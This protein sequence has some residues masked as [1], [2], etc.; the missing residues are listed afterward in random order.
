M[1]I[2][3]DIGGTK[4]RA[5]M[6][7]KRGITDSIEELTIKRGRPDALPRQ[8]MKMINMLVKENRIE[9]DEIGTVGIS[10]PGPFGFSN[11]KRVLTTPNICGGLNANSG[12]DNDWME[13]PLEE[14]LSRHFDIIMENDALSSALV[15]KRLIN[16]IPDD[17][18]YITWST[19]IGGGIVTGG[20][21]VKGSRG[22]A[23]HIGHMI[24]MKDGPLC[25]CGNHGD[26][27]SIASGSAIE[28]Q[29]GLEASSVF[30]SYDSSVE[31]RRIV[32]NAA[33]GFAAGLVSLSALFDTELFIIGG[34][35]FT[36]NSRMLTDL[37][38]RSLS[39]Y[40]PLFTCR[41]RIAETPFDDLALLSALINVMPRDWD[42]QWSKNMDI[43]T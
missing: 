32:D 10:A 30:E 23:S 34:S 8:V 29:A 43:N 26:L 41:I 17:F 42:G 3:V 19:G 20:S 15:H 11:G 24:L 18:I 38:E 9:E 39:N 40:S 2:G 27:E 31:S 21:P 13:I 1:I 22:N 16:N 35:V 25:N 7:D 28:R 5:V 33:E 12:P 14:E 37:I 4:T 6:A 36:S